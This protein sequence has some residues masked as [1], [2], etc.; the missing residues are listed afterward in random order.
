MDFQ[1]CNINVMVLESDICIEKFSYPVSL[2]SNYTDYA[3]SFFMEARPVPVQPFI[4]YIFSK[5]VFC[6]LQVFV[7][8]KI[9][10]LFNQALFGTDVEVY[11]FPNNRCPLILSKSSKYAWTNCVAILAGLTHKTW[12]NYSA[13]KSSNRLDAKGFW[14]TEQTGGILQIQ[15][16]VLFAVEQ[17]ED[18]IF[19]NKTEMVQEIKLNGCIYLCRL[20]WSWNDSHVPFQVSFAKVILLTLL[21]L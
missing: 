19:N 6:T 2:S 13:T 12:T 5:H 15:Y 1:D 20:C 4:K 11:V 18:R 14:Y 9:Q 7:L 3:Q 21:N 8:T 10:T 17:T 16:F